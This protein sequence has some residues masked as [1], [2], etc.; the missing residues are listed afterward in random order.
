ML[1][2]LD[3][4]LGQVVESAARVL[5]RRKF[6]SRTI[7]GIFAAVAGITV[8]EF[9]NIQSAAAACNPTCNWVNGNHCSG[10][11]FYG[12]C[13][14]TYNVCTQSS[15]CGGNLCP[16]PNGQWTV[17]GC[18]HVGKCFMGFYLC[19]D[20]MIGDC[21]GLCTCLSGCIC[22]SCCTP[23]DV[24]AEMRRLTAAATQGVIVHP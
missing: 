10:C 23:A 24:E 2:D 9:I 15:G 11:P 18:D 14:S 6:L 19:T 13:P 8:G 5:D 12:G 7:K 16:Y 1:D 20:C 22:C 3:R 4:Q 17:S 21:T